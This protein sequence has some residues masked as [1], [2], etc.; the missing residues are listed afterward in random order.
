MLSPTI[1]NQQAKRDMGQ[2][3]TRLGGRKLW[4][5]RLAWLLVIFLV[6]AVLSEIVPGNYTVTYR[7]W[8]VTQA[9]PALGSN[10]FA[11]ETFVRIL[12]VLESAVAL[13]CILM[14]LIVFRYKSDDG[15]GLF[16]SAT[17]IMLS[18]LAISNNVDTWR[19]PRWLPVP[20]IMSGLL[21]TMVIS[22][23]L[24]FFHLFPDGRFEPRWTRWPAYLGIVGVALFALSPY[25]A[26]GWLDQ[27]AGDAFWYFFGVAV[28]VSMIAALLSQV[29]HYRAAG[30]ARR[31][32]MKWV[33]FGLVA[34]MSSLLW[35]LLA[36]T[37][38]GRGW[39]ALIGAPYEHISLAL[40]VLIVGGT[41]VMFQTQIRTTSVIV[42]IIISSLILP[43]VYRRWQNMMN[44]FVP[45]PERTPSPVAIDAPTIA[46][47]LTLLTGRPLLLAR[48]TWGVVALLSL[49]IF[50]A[51]LQMALAT[52]L[53][54]QIP[55]L[56]AEIEVALFSIFANNPL[57]ANN[58]ILFAGFVH[59]LA[60]TCAGLV[61]FWRKSNDWLAILAATMLIST[62]AGFSPAVFFLP[63]LRPAWHI[64]VSL[65]QAI[66]FSTLLWF[67]YLF[68]NGRFVPTW[69]RPAALL[70][71]LYAIGWLIFPQLNPHRAGDF[72]ALLIFIAWAWTGI[73][74]QIYRYRQTGRM[75][76]QQ[77]KWVMIGFF[78]T[79]LFFGS[80]AVSS[81]VGLNQRL[82]EIAPFPIQLLN[83]LFGFS[84]IFIP[85]TIAFAIL[86]YRLWD[87]DV[88]I[89]RTLV[90]GTL[91]ALVA[92]VYVLVVGLL[93]VLFQAGGSVLISVLATGLIA[94]LF[95]PLR[96]R[97]Q[98]GVNRLMYGD[99]DDPETAITRM[100][101][102]LEGTAA[103]DEVLPALAETVAH[104]LKLP[105]VAVA[106]REGDEFPIAAEYS[107]S[108]A[109]GDSEAEVFPL[110]Y[111]SE[112]VGQLLVTPRAA[113]EPF[114]PADRRLLD[115]VARQAGTAVHAVQLTS[116]LQRSRERLVT[117]REEE[118]R[119]LHRDL[120]DGLGPQLATLSLK[121]DA[122]RNH[123]SENTEATDRLLV[124]L[125]SQIQDAIQ[126][127]R[128]LVYELRPPALDQL[129]LVSALQEYAASQNGHQG[130]QITVEA[131]ETL[132]SLPAAVEVAAYRIVME[133]LTNVARHAQARTCNVRLWMEDG[134]QLEVK[135]DGQGL[136]PL[137]DVGVGLT[138]MQERAAELGGTLT[139]ETSAGGGTAVRASL[140]LTDTETVRDGTYSNPHR[141]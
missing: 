141:R 85:I 79:H 61:L 20:P 21:M 59:F 45:L 97:L 120:H 77:Q 25:L 139:V 134:L 19:F 51:S 125:K 90:Y 117:A 27:V 38:L 4:L 55:D 24:L 140:P 40:I 136:P 23:F 11:Y 102:R 18:L 135:D 103:P 101:K 100:G 35:N 72:T 9:R 66:L 92:A 2:P 50:V 132:P 82:L 89:N 14:G 93:G 33:I 34:W 73:V 57:L 84:S 130:L 112:M 7:E 1:A 83:V 95:N 115:D 70:W 15:M 123:L 71:S 88:W 107:S 48:L 87:V 39:D 137:Y 118:R 12:T 52:D 47:S 109:N 32:Q 64:P 110:V 44:Q 29:H 49:I 108:R 76:R 124:E 22:S 63:I 91:T 105:Y 3:H 74:A 53:F 36:N 81:A 28:L 30:R 68:P 96:L 86:R 129:G 31:Q 62:G 60:F 127:I 116:Q 75:E 128:R 121:V 67:L 58:A 122:A 126:D 37:F 94:I 104:T 119:R 42:A 6:V 17:L 114:T 69:T 56:A 13:L 8:F 41:A 111:Q 78:L 46:P 16:V 54:T 106:V 26:W 133:A 98:E 138:S 10:P 5:A 43:T 131:P 65:L 99:R 80:L 113:N